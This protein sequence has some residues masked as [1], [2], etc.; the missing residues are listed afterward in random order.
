[1]RNGS[2][3]KGRVE[4][5]TYS[6]A[7]ARLDQPAPGEVVCGRRKCF[8]EARNGDHACAVVV[9]EG[10]VLDNQPECRWRLQPHSHRLRVPVDLLCV[11]ALVIATE[12]D[13]ARGAGA[14]R[15]WQVVADDERPHEQVL[16]PHATELGPRAVAKGNPMPSAPTISMPRWQLS[17]D[18]PS[19]R[20]NAATDVMVMPFLVFRHE[21]WR[22]KCA[23]TYRLLGDDS[24]H[25]LRAFG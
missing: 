3:R 12:E 23:I 7:K 8:G 1:M 20:L 15:A 13:V 11:L 24:A 4:N 16:R 18:T 17:A 6:V 14:L 25:E 19:I 2:K 21:K 9:D 5:D 22:I 10:R